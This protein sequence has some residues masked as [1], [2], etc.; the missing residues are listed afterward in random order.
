MYEWL[1]DDIRHETLCT[2]TILSILLSTDN[3]NIY[4][5]KIWL[6]VSSY[7]F[8]RIFYV[9]LPCLFS[10]NFYFHSKEPFSP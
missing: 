5:H 7:V 8:Q 3:E 2:T 9:L 1:K 6:Y 10:R 4:D